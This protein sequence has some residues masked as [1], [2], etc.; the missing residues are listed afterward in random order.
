MT[1]ALEP[2]KKRL[3]VMLAINAVA[4]LAAVGFALGHYVGGVDWMQW[5]F[6]AALGAGFA[7]QIWF[8]AGFR[9]AGRGV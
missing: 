8:I 6:M 4:A 7:A 3:V 2:I 5:A 1:A 9:R